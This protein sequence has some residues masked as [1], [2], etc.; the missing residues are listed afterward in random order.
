MQNIAYWAGIFGIPGVFSAVMVM[1]ISYYFKRAEAREIFN[2]AACKKE[3]ILIMKSLN[4]NGALAEA[5][6][7]AMQNGKANGEMEKALAYY[8]NVKN[9]MNDYLLQRNAES[10][11]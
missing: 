10:L 5:T 4:A 6:A 2:S 9:E 1:I 7:L 8:K 11:H 3:N